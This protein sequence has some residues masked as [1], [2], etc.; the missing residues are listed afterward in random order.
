MS[1]D[2]IMDWHEYHERQA[3]AEKAEKER[4]AAQAQAAT[5][6]APSVASA[7]ANAKII[8]LAERGASLHIDCGERQHVYP[9][10]YF[11]DLVAG[12]PVEPLPDD[13]LR[14]IVAEWLAGLDLG[15][16]LARMLGR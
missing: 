15:L 6:A 12:R 8:N 7:P 3:A 13:V 5:A 10:A 1:Y 14:L 9:V 2:P 11:R 16:A 4:K